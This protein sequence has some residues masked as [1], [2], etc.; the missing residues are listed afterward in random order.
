[1]KKSH[2]SVDSQ[3][4]VLYKLTTGKWKHFSKLFDASIKLIV[5]KPYK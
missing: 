1:M 3:I 2:N 4:E 5:Q